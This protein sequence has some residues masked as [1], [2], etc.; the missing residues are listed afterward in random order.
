MEKIL[1]DF[2]VNWMLLSAQVVNFLVLL[3]ILQK[4]L[5][6]PILKMLDLRRQKIEESLLNAEKIQKELEETEAS[7]EKVINEAIEEGRKII[8]E[9]TAQ[10]TLLMAESQAK[11]RED[12]EAMMEQ[13]K[14]MIAGEKDKMT[15]EVK[16]DVARMIEMSLEKVLGSALDSKAQGRLVDE[17]VKSIKS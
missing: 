10:G 12:M 14:A 1:S 15:R 6:K 8:S 16:A 2:G 11:A 7:R 17:A 9:A 3:F 5:Y 4:L 13:G